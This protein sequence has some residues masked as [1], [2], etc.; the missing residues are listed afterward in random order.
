VTTD[1][2]AGGDRLWSEAAAET[3]AELTG[4]VRKRAK[5]I[6]GDVDVE[7]VHDMRT[8]TRRLRTAITIYGEDADKDDREAVEDELRRI[9]RRLG[10]VRDLDVLLETLD[11]A[12]TA[13]GGKIDPDDFDP[14]RR[15]W[16]DERA[17]GAERLTAE[18]GRGRFDA[19]LAGAEQLGKAAHGGAG[20]GSGDGDQ[21]LRVAHRAPTL[22]WASF[23]EVLAYEI[24]PL[25]ADPAAIHEMRIAAKKLR[26]TLEAFQD[27]LEPGATLIDEVTALQDAGGEMHDAIVARDRARETTQGAGDLGKAE[28]AA[29][30]SFAEEQDRRAESC[31]PI[32]ARCLTT[33][34]SRAFRASLARA[35]VGMGHVAPR[36]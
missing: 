15:S 14:L 24:D 2:K 13:R 7:A 17:A 6:H 4:K 36:S 27:A 20:E 11:G 32:T 29:I 1:V 35:L 26:Y 18:L 5:A 10:A 33:V 9:T 22:I 8:A 12:S 30:E 34:R 23:G 25:T 28:R 16:D 31:R 3:L 21:Q 19:A